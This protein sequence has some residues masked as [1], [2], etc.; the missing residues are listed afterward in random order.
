MAV[1]YTENI[2]TLD[3]AFAKS[4]TGYWE[5]SGLLNIGTYATGGVAVA[6]S[7]FDSSGLASTIEHIQ[8]AGV[9]NDAVLFYSW[10][11]TNTKIQ[12]FDAIGT[13]EGNGVDISA[14]AKS[15]WVTVKLS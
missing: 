9:S 11:K 7:D 10:D 3:K 2:G 14:A 1:T 4:V 12:A 5:T 13:E 15:V 6:A 8:L